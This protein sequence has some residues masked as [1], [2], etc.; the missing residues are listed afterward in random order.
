[1]TA[2][3]EEQSPC[4]VP[5]DAVSAPSADGDS[6]SPLTVFFTA[7]FAT[8]CAAIL[9]MLLQRRRPRPSPRPH[10]RSNDP[11]PLA[12]PAMCA[13]ARA[14]ISID[15]DPE[16]RQQVHQMLSD[17]LQHPSR[18]TRLTAALDTSN[19]LRF[20]TAGLRARVG[21]GY[22]RLNCLVILAAA[23]ALANVSNPVSRVVVV[24]HDARAQSRKFAV[25][26]ADVFRLFG[27]QVKLFSRPVP[28]PWV[29]FAVRHYEAALG[30]CV[31]ASH[32]PPQDNGLKVFW[33][34]GVQIRPDIANKVELILKDCSR[35]WHNYSISDQQLPP[36]PDPYHDVTEKYFSAITSALYNPITDPNHQKIVYTALHGVGTPFVA[37][38]FRR[39]Q[40]PPFI[41]VEEQCAPDPKFPTVPFPN[42]E[43]KGALDLAIRTAKR[44]NARIIIANDPDADRLGIAEIARDGSVR[45]FT[46]DEIAV[47]LTDY[48]TTHL[49]KNLSQCGVVASTVSSKI[50]ASM[51]RKRGFHFREALTGFKWINKVAL[52]MEFEGMTSILA[53][54]EALGYN[55]TRN[56]VCDKDGVSAAAVVAQMVTMIY[57]AGETLSERL[58]E[59]I[60]ECGNHISRNGYYKLTDSSPSTAAVFESARKG[61]LPSTLADA[62]VNSVRDLTCGTD[63][64]ESN[65]I[66]RLPGDTSTQFITFRCSGPSRKGEDC[67]LVIH[68]RG[69]GTEPKIKYYSELRTTAKERDSGSAQRFLK[70]AVQDAVS[71][72]LRPS[73]N[74]LHHG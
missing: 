1:M 53:Y 47:L 74:N 63:S 23:Q 70:K 39:F 59:S 37:E 31:T 20:G 10:P 60:T 51:A 4:S 68:L 34:D 48:L 33:S 35:P 15:P 49:Y 62:V 73:E 50:L 18:P 12:A 26:V 38:I 36:L 13:L 57:S 40:L 67:P 3:T 6:Y 66:A 55:V 52:D 69:S 58:Q 16:T 8:A 29:A 21:A 25:L 2:P 72:V 5:S 45:I 30:L 71:K 28:T 54:E 11:A 46:G 22:D 27:A 17:Y 14:W 7:A 32:N 19:R 56:I 9:S 42:P 64:A 43:E 44:N 61:G 65:G 24:G 41:P